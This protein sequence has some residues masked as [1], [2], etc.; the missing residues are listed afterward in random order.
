MAS[1]STLRS[2]C[3]EYYRLA[4]LLTGEPARAEAALSE[5]AREGG[6]QFAQIRDEKRRAAWFVRRL[7]ERCTDA[8]PEPGE[9]EHG[10]IPAGAR[11][12]VERISRMPEPDRSAVALFYLNRFTGREIAHILDMRIEQLSET[13]RQGRETLAEVVRIGEGQGA[14]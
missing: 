10:Q 3:G 6:A 11:E 14:S 7:R 1:E 9:G 12:V 4:L 2:D 13:L 5:V 8:I